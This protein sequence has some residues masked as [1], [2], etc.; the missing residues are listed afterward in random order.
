MPHR[1]Q[2]TGPCEHKD[3]W[4]PEAVIFG[5]TQHGAMADVVCMSCGW[6]GRVPLAWPLTQE[7]GT[8]D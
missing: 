4:V 2:A 1:A 3:A 8:D 5:G 6:Q 7:E